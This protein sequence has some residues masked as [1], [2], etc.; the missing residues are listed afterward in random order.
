[1]RLGSDFCEH[2]GMIFTEVMALRSPAELASYADGKDLVPSTTG[3]CSEAIRGKA[4]RA[5]DDG[6]TPLIVALRAARPRR[7]RA[8]LHRPGSA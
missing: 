7:W 2:N 6:E 5:Q 3:M 8:Q 1:M 4:G